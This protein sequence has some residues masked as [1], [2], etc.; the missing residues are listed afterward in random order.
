MLKSAVTDFSGFK[1]LLGTI[2]FPAA[3][4]VFL[5]ELAGG[6]TVRAP[7][8]QRTGAVTDSGLIAHSGN[9]FSDS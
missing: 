1:S 8:E 2:R 5:P 7:R 6:V 9:F 3:D 4:S